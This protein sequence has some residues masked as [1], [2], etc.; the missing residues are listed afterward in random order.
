[1][2]SETGNGDGNETPRRSDL[3]GVTAL[4]EKIGVAKST[5]S[6]QAHSGKIPVADW[7]DEGA[8]LFD[9]AEVEKAREANL[10]PNMRRDDDEADDG[11]E[12][13]SQSGRPMSGLTAVMIEERQVRTRSLQLKQAVDE[14][15]LVIAAEVEREQTTTARA[16]RDAV[17]QYV[18]D[19]DGKAYAFA[20]QPRTQAEWRHFLIGIVR[21][22]YAERERSLAEE[23]DDEL[24]DDIDAAGGNA[25]PQSAGTS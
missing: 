3:L 8:P 10:N 12:R 2:V 4:A 7:T 11:N 20:G 16:T 22:A 6:K 24:D 19:C 5:V 15:L 17:Q 9:L 1:M 21:D 23:A 13:R 14:G 25:E 18:A